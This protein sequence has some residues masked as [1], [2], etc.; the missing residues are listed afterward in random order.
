[1]SENDHDRAARAGEVDAGRLSQLAR[2][3][4]AVD[5]DDEVAVEQLLAAAPGLARERGE[6]GV[7]MLLRAQ[8][9]R[10]PRALSALLAAGA[11]L[12]LFEAAA[13]GRL[14][15]VEELFAAEPAAASARSADG[16]TALHLACFFQ[17]P[18]TAAVLV[19]AGADVRAVAEN[20]MRVTPL[21]SAAAVHAHEI[22][23]L[24]LDRGADPDAAQI[25][26]YTALHSAA[27]SGDLEMI[28]LLLAHGADRERRT[29]D[30]RSA[31]D[32]AREAGHLEAAA[33]FEK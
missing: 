7:S 22:A 17:H 28:D 27:H 18:A 10:R 30:G 24:L 3:I 14:E 31:L 32:F 16:F 19:E 2:L 29:D 6:D 25:G 11:P 26:G 5:A 4:A 21:H 33:R 8:Y 20:P 15:R 1:M 13:L 23:A 9:R 12:D